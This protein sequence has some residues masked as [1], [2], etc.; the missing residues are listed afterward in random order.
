MSLPWQ[1]TDVLKEFVKRDKRPGDR[2][3]YDQLWH[4][5]LKKDVVLVGTE[6]LAELR[7]VVKHENDLELTDAGYQALQTI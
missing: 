3:G 4:A 6:A 5:L 2:I 1:A 7:L